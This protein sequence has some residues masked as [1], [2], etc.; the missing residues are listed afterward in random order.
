MDLDDIVWS[1]S[2]RA[3]TDWRFGMGG[4]TSIAA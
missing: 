1:T 2:G 4:E 3:W